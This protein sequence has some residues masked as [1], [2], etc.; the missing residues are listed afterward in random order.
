VARGRLGQSLQTFDQALEVLHGPDGP[1]RVPLGP[2]HFIGK[3]QVL[4]ERNEID[5]ARH[6]LTRGLELSRGR[7][8]IDAEVVT[9][10]YIAMAR[11][12]RA[13]GEYGEAAVTLDGFARLAQ[14]RGYTAHLIRRGAA[15]RA[16]L[17]LAQGELP[18]AMRWAEASG[19]QAEDVITYTRE[20]EY[21]ALV[22]VLIA[23]MRAARGQASHAT[24][25]LQ[26]LDRLLR[27]AE[28]GERWGSVIEISMLQALALQAAGESTAAMTALQRALTLAEPEHYI[29][30]F[31][32]EGQPMARLLH[33]AHGQGRAPDYVAVLLAAL[34]MPAQQS[35]ALQ[36]VGQVSSRG[37]VVNPAVLGPLAQPLSK[38]E[39]AV[40]RLLAAGLSNPEIAR[41]MYVEVST[42]KTHLKGIYGK[43]GVHSREQATAKARKL[44]LL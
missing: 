17:L 10:G 18:A 24:E 21:L 12:Q 15:A 42:V 23:Q 3:G 14:E 7:L 19:L 20:A 1:D 22:R 38:Q 44:Q 30:I 29:R 5:A 36:T 37:T 39:H 40:L 35:G 4:L 27:E 13:C 28:A 33:L 8:T 9:Q 31:A 26:L 41:A 16:Q 34:G 25:T 32:D 43:L 6:C 2:A 11:L